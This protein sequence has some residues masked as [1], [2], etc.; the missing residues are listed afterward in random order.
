MEAAII[1]SNVVSELGNNYMGGSEWV[2]HQ[3]WFSLF[4]CAVSPSSLAVPGVSSF[5]SSSLC[6]PIV[7]VWEFG[8]VSLRYACWL[9][10]VLS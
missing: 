10:F 7:L 8:F 6:P 4:L 1:A 2:F 3:R 5:P 9:G